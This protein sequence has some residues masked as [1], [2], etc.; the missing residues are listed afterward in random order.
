MQQ[1]EDGQHDRLVG[2]VLA[3]AL[4]EDARLVA[5]ELLGARDLAGERILHQ[6]V[7]LRDRV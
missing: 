2:L 5:P 4:P 7:V 1:L 3:D 6:V